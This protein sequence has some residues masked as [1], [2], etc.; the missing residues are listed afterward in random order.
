MHE[1]AG[2]KNGL[3]VLPLRGLEADH[4]SILPRL[5][6][7]EEMHP[8]CIALLGSPSVRLEPQANPPFSR[9]HKPCAAHSTQSARDRSHQSIVQIHLHIAHND[10]DMPPLQSGNSH[11][12]SKLKVSRHPRLEVASASREITPVPRKSPLLRRGRLRSRRA[13]VKRTRARLARR[14]RRVEKLGGIA[15]ILFPPLNST[16]LAG[17]RSAQSSLVYFTAT[18][19]SHDPSAR[20]TRNGNKVHCM[21]P[22]RADSGHQERRRKP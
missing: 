8:T 17:R 3:G 21:V 1:P 22:D 10:G 12:P 7:S 16:P 18:G 11:L 9:S 13:I 20:T 15:A 5:A 4:E 19:R 6:R 2:M 14:I